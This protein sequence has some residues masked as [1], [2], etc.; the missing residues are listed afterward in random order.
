MRT[1]SF[2]FIG[3]LLM[4]VLL[5]VSAD[6]FAQKGNGRGNGPGKGQGNFYNN[7]PDLTA[8]QQSKIEQFRTAH[9]RSMMALRNQIGEKQAHLQT[10]RTAD[11][12]DLN[13]INKT[14]DEMSTLRTSMMKMRELHIQNIRSILTDDQRV[15]FDNMKRG[16]G[17]GG[18]GM[19]Q[20]HGN[21]MGKGPGPGRCG[22]NR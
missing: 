15:F 6:L 3:L 18:R 14:I 8:D 5:N 21:G 17:H 13:A 12:A 2:G 16:P 1:K 20:G 22:G 11:N 9:M 7:I 4:A 10:L 19:G